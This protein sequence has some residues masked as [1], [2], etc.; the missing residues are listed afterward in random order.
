MIQIFQT[1][2]MRIVWQTVR[3]I[4]NEILGVKGLK[5]E[6]RAE[7]L[8]T[9]NWGREMKNAQW[10]MSNRSWAMSNGQWAMGNGQWAMG[11]GQ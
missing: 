9:G 7:E 1:D 8:G 2:I 6:W 4:T 3:R 5:E 11:N 10:A